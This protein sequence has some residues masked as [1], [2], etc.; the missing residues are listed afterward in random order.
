M[1]LKSQPE[2]K[3]GILAEPVVRFTLL[4]EYHLPD[5]QIPVK[6]N[7]TACLKNGKIE[8]SDDTGIVTT[9]P[10]IDLMPM[11]ENPAF[12]VSG[13][14]IGISF[15][16]EQKE[17]QRFTGG[18]QLIPENGN[19]RLI[20]RIKLE[21]YLESVIASEMSSTASVA[22]LKA[23]AVISR[24]WLL[25]QIEKRDTL[26]K[27]ETRFPNP[28]SDNDT[29]IKW[30]DREDHDSFDVCADDHCQRYHGITKIRSP[31]AIQAV[32]ET[33]GEILQYDGKICD[34]RFSKCCGGISENF[35]NAWE[36]VHYPY[37]SMIVDSESGHPDFNTDL[38]AEVHAEKWIR[39]SP[40]AFCNT[41]DQTVLSQV[42]PD[43][44]QSTTDFY[45]WKKEYSQEEL[46]ALILKK[47]GHDFGKII[48][49]EPVERG[50]SGR[51]VKLRITGSKK[52]LVVGKEL[53]IRKW[54]SVSH[55]Y[56][57]AFVV[58]YADVQDGIPDRI[59]LTGAGWGHGV[60][61]CQIGAAVMGEKGYLYDYILRH[62]F[63]GSE[64]I[65]LY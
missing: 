55:L 39:N 37:L 58:D 61:L 41:S 59:I 40:P 9:A 51:L 8:L 32:R 27:K 10:V 11:S 16:W 31:K 6:G 63:V 29:Y 3:A 5:K 23:H 2:L 56:S 21:E 43:F 52:I 46:S 48:R 44:D 24:S 35:E 50:Y 25:A 33:S 20:N 19:V 42:L 12:E 65:K 47:S 14:T 64:L 18:I 15:H 57:S 54:L 7:F 34:A 1:N 28:V 62:Y 30:Y 49:L 60:G 45:R 36:P 4:S 17:I 13:V 26:K 38:T 53:E 22:L